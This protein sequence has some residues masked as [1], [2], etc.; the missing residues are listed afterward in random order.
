MKKIIFFTIFILALFGREIATG[1]VIVIVGG[2]SRTGTVEEIDRQLDP[3]KEALEK[4]GHRV[5]VVRPTT[6]IPLSTASEELYAELEREDIFKENIVLLGWCW[7]GLI[8]RRFAE[9]YQDAVNVKAIIQIASPNE[10]Y[11]FSPKF[12]FVTNAKKSKEIPLFVVAGNKSAKKWYL[13]SE[14]DGTVD[15]AS[16]LSVPS[17]KQAVFPL[18]HLELIASQEVAEKVIEWIKSD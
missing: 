4:I 8:S 11:W 17:K 13:R 5:V 18:S 2:W 10:G 3:M 6:Y 14:N 7:G 1:E 9:Q 15:T 16:V 12:I